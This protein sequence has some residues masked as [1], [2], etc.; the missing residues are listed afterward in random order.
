V[1]R[2]FGVTIPALT[3]DYAELCA[4]IDALRS[5]IDH[6]LHVHLELDSPNGI[7]G[8]MR[9]RLR[10][11]VDTL[12]CSRTVRGKGAAVHAGL[13]HLFDAGC[14]RIGFLDADGAVAPESAARL[15]RAKAPVAIGT[16]WRASPFER[17]D[18]PLVRRATSATLRVAC[19]VVGGP[20]LVDYQCG[21]KVLDAAAW[22]AV[23]DHLDEPGFAW[24]LQLVSVVDAL[25]LPI[26][27]L[28]VEWAN[29]ST[30]TTSA[31]SAWSFVRTL[32]RLPSTRRA[33]RKQ[34]DGDATTATR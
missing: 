32:A 23:R 26:A 16:R 17:T 15:F 11:A 24:D 34:P 31:R 6:P 7:P 18:R 27:E 13:D 5:S 22:V 33:V 2:T 19:R 30:T 25:D 4:Y 10:T 21:G 14:D 1:S 29:G 9:P 8:P 3:P 28:P 12:T 20:T